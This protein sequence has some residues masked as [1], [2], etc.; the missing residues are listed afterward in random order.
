MSL[1]ALCQEVENR[2]AGAPCGVMDQVT[3]C[4]G[5]KGS[6]LRLVCQ[7]HELEPPLSLP[8]G[9]RI[10]GIHSGTRH[11]IANGQYGRTRSAAFMGHR[12][13]LAKMKQMGEASGHVLTADPMN[14]YLA[15]LPLE[16]YKQYFRPFLPEKMRGDQFIATYGMTID[17]ATRI[18]PAV[19]YTVQSAT[20]HHV[21]EPTR[22]RNFVSFIEKANALEPRTAERSR[23][24]DMAGH[25]MYASHVSYTRDALLGADE[26]DLLVDLVRRY[27][28]EGYYGAKITG[29]GQGGTV[30]ILCNTGPRTDEGLASLMAEYQERTGRQTTL[31][32][33]SSAGAW[34]VGTAVVSSQ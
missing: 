3:S 24:L 12:I 16:D 15:N 19:E 28:R 26:C 5:E 8:E 29:G 20:D 21:H 27:E 9:I 31:F 6:L 22:V 33:G 25:L 1:A 30:A 34:S 2:I 32:A 10:V 17:T 14:G 11:S 4:L 13:I 7:P 18:E 23:Y